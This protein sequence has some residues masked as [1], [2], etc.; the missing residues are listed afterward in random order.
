MS[1]RLRHTFARNTSTLVT[2][3]HCMP[4]RQR[5]THVHV[6]LH[7]TTQHALVPTI[8]NVQRPEASLYVLMTPGMPTRPPRR[9]SQR[10]LPPPNHSRHARPP[11]LHLRRLA[12]SHQP[13]APPPR[14][15]HTRKAYQGALYSLLSPA[16][17]SQPCAPTL[18]PQ[19]PRAPPNAAFSATPRPYRP[20]ALPLGGGRPTRSPLGC[21][22][23]DNKSLYPRRT[24]DAPTFH[25]VHL[26]LT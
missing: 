24:S 6:R 11:P 2:P 8:V 7:H 20:P 16:V 17:T 25:G 14:T 22:G 1:T 10:P 19:L 9:P 21:A 4:T 15:R 3:P 23:S 12:C 5:H 26:A 13:E 18:R